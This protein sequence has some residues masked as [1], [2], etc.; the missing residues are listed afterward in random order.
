MTENGRRGAFLRDLF[1]VLPE[2]RLPRSRYALCLL[3]WAV[4]LAASAMAASWLLARGGPAWAAAGAA[5]VSGWFALTASVRRLH[6]IGRSGWWVIAAAAL[7]PL[8]LLVLLSMEGRPGEN[9]WG[10]N[11]KGL[12][13]IDD[14]RL[15]ERL[16]R[17]SRPGSAMDEILSGKGAAA[18]QGAGSQNQGGCNGKDS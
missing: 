18:P 13:R 16:A 6:D 15:L 2:G 8:G 9:R 11:P 7:L 10:E 14:E 1:A 4:A 3:V 17:E 5:A 12:L